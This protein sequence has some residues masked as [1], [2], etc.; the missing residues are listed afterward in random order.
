MTG[1]ALHAACL[2]HLAT[3]QL[4][5]GNARG[6]GGQCTATHAAVGQMGARLAG[7]LAAA[8]WA[9]A[10]PCYGPLGTAVLVMHRQQQEWQVG[11]GAH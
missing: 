2:W 9:V 3:S 4:S 7:P 11:W 8:A 5:I 1:S 10:F 6:G